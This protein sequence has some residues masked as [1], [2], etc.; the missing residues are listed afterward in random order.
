MNIKPED[1]AALEKFFSNITLPDELQLN[2][3]IRYTRLPHFVYTNLDLLRAGKITG[4]TAKL[5]FDDLVD[6]KN[7]LE[8][9][10]KNKLTFFS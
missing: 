1:I 4:S 6:I 7:L 3:A 2:P 8:T 5:R 9:N 10:L